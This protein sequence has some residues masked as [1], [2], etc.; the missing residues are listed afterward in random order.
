MNCW[1]LNVDKAV[2]TTPADGLG[3]GLGGH[4]YGL[5]PGT[6]L[7]FH[8]GCSIKFLSSFLWG[9]G[10]NHLERRQWIQFFLAR[11]VFMKIVL[12]QPNQLGFDGSLTGLGKGKCPTPAPSSHHI[13]PKEEK[14]LRGSCDIHSPGNRPHSG[15]QNPSLPTFTTIS[16]KACSPKFLSPSTSCLAFRKKKKKN[17]GWKTEQGSEPDIDMAD[18]LK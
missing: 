6:I 3:M 1:K 2:L 18:M 9:M 11:P 17:T 8:S 14:I 10:R 5:L 15:P 4:F 12:P 7:G 16:L 13:P